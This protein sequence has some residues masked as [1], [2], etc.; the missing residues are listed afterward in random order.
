MAIIGAAVAPVAGAADFPSHQSIEMR[1]GGSSIA[2]DAQLGSRVA[3]AARDVMTH[4]GYNTLQHPGNFGSARASPAARWNQALAGA[5]LHVR[6]A[7]PF[8]SRSGPG[9]A[10]P[11]T[12]VL[13]AFEQDDHIGPGFTRNGDTVVEHIRC[14]D[15]YAL[16]LMCMRELAPHFPAS[17]RRNC[18]HLRFG[19]DGRPLDLPVDIAPSCS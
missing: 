1:V 17:Y 2:F 11:V 14:G 8:E 16:E 18:V 19:T 6:F 12:E 3:R 15:K 9:D 10:L 7:A 13:I 4:C 5:Y